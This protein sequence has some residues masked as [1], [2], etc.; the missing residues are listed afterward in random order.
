MNQITCLHVLENEKN[1]YL[2]Q[3]KSFLIITDVTFIS[4]TDEIINK[5]AAKVL[6][7]LANH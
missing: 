4:T 6:T 5:V 1:I 7:T 3:L 2:V